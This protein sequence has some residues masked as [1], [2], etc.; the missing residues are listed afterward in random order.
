MK[1]IFLY[2]ILCILI[3]SCENKPTGSKQEIATQLSE[4]LINEFEFQ[5]FSFF[6][7]EL[8]TLNKSAKGLCFNREYKTFEELVEGMPTL[9]LFVPQNT[10]FQCY[11]E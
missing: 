4:N 1:K 10:C 11:S 7:Y 5:L 3:I 6:K 8:D 9:F 2:F